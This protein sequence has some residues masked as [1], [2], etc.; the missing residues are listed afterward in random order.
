M[1]G[2]CAPAEQSE[3]C[4]A[5][6]GLHPPI[7]CGQGAIAR[8]GRVRGYSTRRDLN[9]PALFK[10]GAWE[11]HQHWLATDRK[12]P[13]SAEHGD[14]RR[15]AIPLEGIGKP[16]PLKGDLSGWWSRRITDEHRLVCTE[17]PGRGNPTRSSRVAACRFHY[18]GR[19]MSDP[20]AWASPVV[21]G[22]RCREFHDRNRP[23]I[24]IALLP[25]RVDP[26]RRH[27]E[28]SRGHPPKIN[29]AS[30]SRRGGAPASRA[31]IRPGA[32]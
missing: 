3:K 14:Q 16:E 15:P 28:N 31:P 19:R 27:Q 25:P 32:D 17:L 12:V 9:G 30:V 7:G 24:G 11:D 21:L 20:R 29:E 23:N 18:A 5:T 8:T 13:A 2:D 10:G 22:T 26:A 6:V 1:A 4:R